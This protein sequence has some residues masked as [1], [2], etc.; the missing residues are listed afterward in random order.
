MILFLQSTLSRYHVCLSNG[1]LF[2]NLTCYDYQLT[3][4]YFVLG[5]KKLS[6]TFLRTTTVVHPV[7][8]LSGDDAATFNTWFKALFDYNSD[9]I[10]DTIFR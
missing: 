10:E 2:R 1:Q 6:V 9:G 4:E 5:D 3:Q 7:G 8:D